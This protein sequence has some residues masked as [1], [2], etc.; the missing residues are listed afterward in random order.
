M[1]SG[2]AADRTADARASNKARR[3]RARERY[4]ADEGNNG[5]K[6][7][8]ARLWPG[9]GTK[10][11]PA[12]PGPLDCL[13][14]IMAGRYRAFVRQQRPLFKI[15]YFSSS[16]VK[17]LFRFYSVSAP[18]R[19]VELM[20]ITLPHAAA[21]SSGQR[22]GC[23]PDQRPGEAAR[24]APPNSPQ[25]SWRT[26]GTAWRRRGAACAQEQG[27]SLP[28]DCRRAR[29]SG[30]W[31]LGAPASLF[32]ALPPGSAARPSL[33][34]GNPVRCLGV[35]RSR[36]TRGGNKSL[37]SLLRPK[38]ISRPSRVRDNAPTGAALTLI[39]PPTDRPRMGWLGWLTSSGAWRAPTFPAH[40]FFLF[41]LQIGRQNNS[42]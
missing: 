38:Y 41:S 8:A 39:S 35:A 6:Q 25:T 23:V 21:A 30:P 3:A 22:A 7:A 19:L 29:R 1:R 31:C 15:F 40:Y 5:R 2:G 34:A 28:Y 11:P 9:R 14:C 4:P 20:M 33:F 36:R 32:C 26:R 42:Q 24:T 37:V 10:G 17:T 13:A 12:R 18:E 16:P 27:V